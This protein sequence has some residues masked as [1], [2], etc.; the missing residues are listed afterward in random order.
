MRTKAYRSSLDK[1]TRFDRHFFDSSIRFTYI[2][3]GELGG[4]A[5]GLAFISDVLAYKYNPQDFPE[6]EVN[7]PTMAVI[8][9]D[10]FDE[11]M[12]LNHLYDLA[13]TDMRDDQIA[14]AFQKASLPAE[15]VG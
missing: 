3:S 15:L 1:L 5:Q 6:I 2:G 7:V 12:R 13:V 9:T 14:L 11:F 8:A 10:V 4:K